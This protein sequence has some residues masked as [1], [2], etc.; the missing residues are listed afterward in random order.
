MLSFVFRLVTCQLAGCSPA[1]EHPVISAAG[2]K[3][4]TCLPSGILFAFGQPWVIEW[5][6]C[7]R[8][9]YLPLGSLLAF[10]QPVCLRAAYLPS[11]SLL[12]FEWLTTLPARQPWVDRNVLAVS[13]VTPTMASFRVHYISDSM[14]KHVG[15]AFQHL[16]Y[17]CYE[18]ITCAPGSEI[19]KVPELSRQC[20]ENCDLLVVNTGINNL[21]NHYSVA[22]SMYLFEQVYKEL[23][24][25]HP[26]SELAFTSISYIADDK[27]SGIDKSCEV[28]PLV[29]ELNESLRTF[30]LNHDHM[31]FFDLRP[32]LGTN[33][34]I[35][36]ENLSADG[37]HYSH[38]GIQIV[39]KTLICEVDTL[40]CKTESFRIHKRISWRSYEH[41]IMAS[42]SCTW[43]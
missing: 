29:K 21:L 4:A 7:L 40:C 6:I 28:N 39:A 24:E 33:A 13:T 32:H 30:C 5:F 31:H 1:C 14:L 43:Y 34:A 25:L 18:K 2:E 19:T 8:A 16:D 20:N 17:D 10:G 35:E 37:L 36:R 23:S 3:T 11:G 41:W 26:M 12:A 27:F 22:N 42:T 9:A 15:Q 38:K